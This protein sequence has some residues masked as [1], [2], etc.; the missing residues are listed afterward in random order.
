MKYKGYIIDGGD[1]VCELC[2]LPD[3]DYITVDQEALKIDSNCSFCGREL[4]K[5]DK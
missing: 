1:F 4:K 5:G 3:D 2:L